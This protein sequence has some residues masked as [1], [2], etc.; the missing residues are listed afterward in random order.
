MRRFLETL[1]TL[2]TALLLV[3]TW[4]VEPYSVVSGS[5]HPTLRGPHY[6]FHCPV[7]GARNFPAADRPWS[8]DA[9]LPCTACSRSEQRVGDLPIVPGDAVLVDRTAFWRRAPRRGEVIVFRLPGEESKIAVK[10]VVG[11]PGERIELRDGK[12]WANDG[13]VSLPREVDYSLPAWQGG[14]RRWQLG[15]DEYF[16]A[17]DNPAVSD[18]S[19]TWQI[20]PG[21]AAQ[22]IVGKPV[23][24]HA[25]RRS[26]HWFGL[27]FHV[28]DVSAIGYIR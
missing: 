3:G 20:G 24:V 7:C 14:P 15:P 17:G 21:V 5:M 28:P 25:P 22:L 26:V 2:M 8:R 10:R 23:I 9:R 4:L 13:P 11:L 6:D 27:P 12:F 18:D 19:R 16:V 1:V